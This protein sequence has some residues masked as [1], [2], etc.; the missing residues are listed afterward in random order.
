M[1]IDTF[2]LAR[3]R[4]VPVRELGGERSL[5]SGCQALEGAERF[6][7][8]VSDPLEYAAVVRFLAAVLSACGLGAASEEEYRLRCVGSVRVNWDRASRWLAEHA[9]DVDILHPQRPLFQD[10]ALRALSR[11]HALPVRYLDH[12]AA[13]ALGR[14]LLGDHRHLYA[15][16]PA[17]EPARAAVL[18]LTQQ[19]WAIGGRLRCS[20]ATY[21]TGSNYASGTAAC[22]RL[23]WLPD[24]TLAD[25]LNWRAVPVSDPCVPNWTYRVRGGPKERLEPA[26]E[27]DALTWMSR[28]VLLIGDGE[29]RIERA[30]YAQGWHRAPVAPD[31]PGGA[32]IV[33]TGGGKALPCSALATPEDLVPIVDRWWQAAEGS[34]P[35]QIRDVIRQT[36]CSAPLMRVVGIAT[37]QKKVLHLRDTRVPADLLTDERAAGAAEL[38]NSLRF[39]MRQRDVHLGDLAGSFL[40]TDPNFRAADER[41]RARLAARAHRFRAPSPGGK[42]ADRQFLYRFLTACVREKEPDVTSLFITADTPAPSELTPGQMLEKRLHGIRAGVH[43][44]GLL[45]QMRLWAGAPNTPNQASEVVTRD[46]PADYRPAA[47]W[48]AALYATHAQ[49]YFSSFGRTPLPR[50]MRAFGSGKSFGPQHGPTETQ[51]K[52]LLATSRP[53]LLLPTL[54]NL[55]RYAA[56]HE[57]TPSWSALADDLSTWNAATRDRWAAMFYTSQPLTEL[58]QIGAHS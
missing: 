5:V 21:G 41:E 11:V 43:S 19:M 7:L 12:T 56:A 26:G 40:L 39:A 38:L 18:L 15:D 25:A 17:L 48:T 49:M 32:E 37:D 2:S 42:A 10:H 14:P 33:F 8:D 36:G 6:V 34:L 4:W 29:G 52:H 30:H 1:S 35:A 46:L 28:R 57:M 50:L 58:A 54:T 45:G 24:G 20:D 22:G 3:E 16:L 55:V 53:A 31:T 44:R 13:G 23:L 47:V 9:D 27:L 51:M